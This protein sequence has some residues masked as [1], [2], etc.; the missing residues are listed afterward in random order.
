MMK[1]KV[2]KLG[3][4]YIVFVIL[5]FA[6]ASLTSLKLEKDLKTIAEDQT[7]GY[8]YANLCILKDICAQISGLDYHF[9]VPDFIGISSDA[10]QAMLLNECAWDMEHEWQSVVNS[11]FADEIEKTRMFSWSILSIYA[12]EM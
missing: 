12:A 6:S 1:E 7:Y 4:V 8:K 11:S 3:F 9:S 10:L 5:S 2:F